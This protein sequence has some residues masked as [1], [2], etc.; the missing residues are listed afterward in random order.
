M[1]RRE[2][3]EL[4]PVPASEDCQ[5]VDGINTDYYKMK[6]E[7]QRYKA[8]L[9][10]I[11]PDYADYDCQFSIK[12]YSHDFGAYMEVVIYFY[13]PDNFDDDPDESSLDYAFFVES[14]LPDTWEDTNV[15]NFEKYQSTE[16]ARQFATA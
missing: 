16:I 11:F 7:C 15:R 12:T 6:S 8:Q 3:L 10:T 14:N 5:Q 4:G 2:T 9:E 13:P 1:F